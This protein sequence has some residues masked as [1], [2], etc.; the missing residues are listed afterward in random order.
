MARVTMESKLSQGWG[1]SAR[2]RWWAGALLAA[3][4]VLWW[5]ARTRTWPAAE[6]FAEAALA[7]GIADWFAV[8]ALWRRPLGLP[9]PHTALVPR[10]QERLADA[11]ARFVA[12]HVL[13]PAPIGRAVATFGPSAWLAGRLGDPL[14]VRRWLESHGAGLAD[15]VLSEAL[16]AARPGPALARLAR[17]LVRRG[18][19]QR[20]VDWGVA[21]VADALAR[22]PEPV[23]RA[24]AEHS[25]RWVPAWLDRKLADQL[26]AV[27]G[28]ILAG[29]AGAEH[30]WRHDLDHRLD[31]W[32]DRLEH[33][34][35]LGER[36]ARLRDRLLDGGAGQA[37]GDSLARGLAGLVAAW[38]RHLD[39]DPRARARLDRRLAALARAWIGPNRDAIGSF[40]AG[41]VRRWPAD[42]LA[43]RLEAA[44]G[45]ELQSIRINGTLVGGLVGLA[46]YALSGVVGGP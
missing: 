20:L 14:T 7:G 33:D 45:A 19:H 39:V 1:R 36:L 42:T 28:E 35:D 23:A 17:A 40:V 21:V 29:L 11:L 4:A 24:V 31:Q 26:A 32:I 22:D 10:S 3:T 15:G 9:I 37:A 25:G 46:L 5:L 2:R 27:L 18:L 38:A 12:R 43:G 8:T 34:P 16:H 41:V 30:P 44:V 6:A 13:A